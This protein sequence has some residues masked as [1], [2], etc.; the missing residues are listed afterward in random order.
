[1]SAQRTYDGLVLVDTHTPYEVR[2]FPYQSPKDNEITVNVKWTSSSP[3][4]VHQA[5]GGLL[6]EYPMQTGSTGVGIVVEVGPEAT[7][8]QVG[9]EVFGFT[10]PKW[11]THQEYCTA[12]GWM[13]GKIPPG[14]SPEE[15]ATIPENLVT[16]FNTISTDLKLPTP[17]PKP[18]GYSP[19][20]ARSRI[21][22]WGAASS[23]GQLTIQ[24]LRYYG[25][26]HIVGTASPK[27]HAYIKSL[28]AAAVYDYRSP[29]VVDELLASAQGGGDE[30]GP[31]GF[32]L[33]VDC[34]GS[35][36][37]SLAPLAKIAQQGS[38]VAV[39]LP[40]IISRLDGGGKK[41]YSMDAGGSAAW[42]PGVEVSGVRT[43]F[44]HHKNEM[45]R[46]KLQTEIIPALLAQGVVKPNRYR[47]IEGETLLERAKRALDAV[48][49]GVSGEKLVWRVSNE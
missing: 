2:K 30:K 38:I 3:L 44:Y 27:H 5:D 36:D 49:E 35:R 10:P 26:Q 31:G 42:A 45:F 22:I 1:M 14:L 7:H 9:D 18:R 4:H 21:L 37:G 48:R 6:V 17:W 25:Y 39:M 15:A 40:V 23:V 28:G 32:P 13:F 33:I 20:L 29:S 46:E 34:I 12:P 16:A 11:R 19:A 41:T 24:V 8:F 43:H 47:V